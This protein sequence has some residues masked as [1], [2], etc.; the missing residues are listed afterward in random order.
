MIYAIKSIYGTWR[1]ISAQKSL[2]D[3]H[4]D[5]EGI[6]IE[7]DSMIYDHVTID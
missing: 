6:N 2:D 5:M 4:W 7:E 1:S 3:D